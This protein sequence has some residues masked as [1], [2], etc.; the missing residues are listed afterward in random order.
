MS[1]DPTTIFLAARSW[2]KGGQ[3]RKRVRWGRRRRIIGIIRKV[4]ETI[5]LYIDALVVSR[6]L[7]SG[8]LTK[9][10]PKRFVRMRG[11]G[12]RTGV[13][14]P[15]SQRY[16]NVGADASHSTSSSSSFFN[17]SSVFTL[18][19][20][21]VSGGPS[22]HRSGSSYSGQSDA[23]LYKCKR[24]SHTPSISDSRFILHRIHVVIPGFRIRILLVGE[25][26]IHLVGH[27]DGVGKGERGG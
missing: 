9:V 23:N 4:S 2:G 3:G 8:K 24:S 14:R 1:R 16:E 27:G 17:S 13:L 12:R 10:R 22:K 26:H 18:P 20:S 7:Q 5:F 21:S 11:P 15:S 19:S 6:L 25:R